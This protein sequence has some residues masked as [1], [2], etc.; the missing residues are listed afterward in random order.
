MQRVEE[1][2]NG[3]ITSLVVFAHSTPLHSSR[4]PRDVPSTL[5]LRR[6]RPSQRKAFRPPRHAHLP[7]CLNH[8][9]AARKHLQV[10]LN[11]HIDDVLLSGERDRKFLEGKAGSDLTEVAASIDVTEADG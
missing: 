8:L 7:T 11:L 2:L 9:A 5:T 6:F 10:L 4:L 3:L 1:D